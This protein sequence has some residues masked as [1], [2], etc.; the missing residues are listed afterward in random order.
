VERVEEISTARKMLI[1]VHKSIDIC[2]PISQVFRAWSRDFSRFISRAARAK[3]HRTHSKTSAGP[4]PDASWDTELLALVDNKVISW[5]GQRGNTGKSAGNVHFFE[6]PD[7]STHIEVR[8]VYWPGGA[9]LD[10]APCAHL[11]GVLEP[12]LEEHLKGNSR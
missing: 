7:G 12:V 8:L 11:P 6:N 2:S 5:R 10:G 1:D 9:G 3:K 4:E